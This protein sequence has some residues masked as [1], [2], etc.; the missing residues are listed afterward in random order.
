MDVQSSTRSVFG[1]D[2]IRGEVG[3][4]PLTTEGCGKIGWAT[5]CEVV[6][7]TNKLIL[8]GR[9]TRNSGLVLEEALKTGCLNAGANVLMV[10][11]LPT[12]AVAYLVKECGANLGIVVSG[13]HNPATDN[14][15]KFFSSDGSKINTAVEQ[16]IQTRLREPTTT[17][18]YSKFGQ[19]LPVIDARNRYKQF[20][21]SIIQPRLELNG[22][23]LVL[24]CANGACSQLA[25]EIFE[26][27]G[28]QVTAIGNEP[29][30]TNI[31]VG[32]GSTNPAA[33]AQVVVEQEADLGFAF[34]GD[35]DRVIV[36]D[37]TGQV[38][39]GD[40]I[41]YAFAKE[42]YLLG[43][44]LEGVVSTVMAN[45]GLEHALARLGTRLER[46]DVGDRNVQ[47]LLAKRKWLFGGEP[48]GHIYCRADST[49]GDGI[50]TAMFILQT[51][52]RL[53]SNFES[54]V[55]DLK[56]LPAKLVSVPVNCPEQLTTSEELRRQ[57]A[58]C[59][60]DCEPALRVNV[61][62][63]GTEPVVRILVEGVDAKLVENKATEVATMIVKYIAEK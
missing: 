6:D 39:D 27:L 19:I 41:L 33:L 59:Q 26:E 57:I 17:A 2:G 46:V 49:T 5:G 16:R 24:D 40:Y 10:G 35:G 60:E 36:V 56:K 9:D 8:I 53:N 37:S 15:I 45:F 3:T 42:Q 22:M 11:V 1:T 29:D 58:R 34:D 13:S 23:H 48:S 44:S 32:C 51:C 12:P 18:E 54:I 52:Q 61:R 38:R 28:A 55:A 62:P 31:H 50:V 7:S 43:D 14:G 20:C 30:G 21:Q 47:Q 25:P 4:F 63:S